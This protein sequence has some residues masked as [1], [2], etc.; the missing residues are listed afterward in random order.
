MPRACLS[1]CPGQQRKGAVVDY[2]REREL[3]THVYK[4]RTAACQ[5]AAAGWCKP[6]RLCR[7]PRPSRS[8][9]VPCPS[10]RRRVAVR[11]GEGQV[12]GPNTE[13]VLNTLTHSAPDGHSRPLAG[14]RRGVP[15]NGSSGRARSGY[16]R[17]EVTGLDRRGRA[18]RRNAAPLRSGAAAG[19]DWHRPFPGAARR[20]PFHRRRSGG[21]GRR[22]GRGRRGSACRMRTLKWPGIAQELAPRPEQPGMHDDGKHRHLQVAGRCLAIPYL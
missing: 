18:V 3:V 19:A 10:R 6:S 4:E 12:S 7:R 15:S 9:P 11:D 22:R 20:S 13:Y 21:R 5:P 8:M 17:S 1:H 16:C 14:R 2:L